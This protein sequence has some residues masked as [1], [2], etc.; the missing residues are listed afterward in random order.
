[1][2]VLIGFGLILSV[3]IHREQRIGRRLGNEE[4]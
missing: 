1:M 3:N 2:T 4:G